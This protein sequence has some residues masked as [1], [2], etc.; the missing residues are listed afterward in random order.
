MS[1]LVA[2]VDVAT[3]NVR[4][5]V[6]DPAGG[7]VAAFDARLGSIERGRDADLVLFSGDPFTMTSRIRFVIIDGRI[8]H[9]S[10]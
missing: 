5:Q 6:H 9:E 2:G 8:V 3:A 1:E 7:V 4:V 10:K